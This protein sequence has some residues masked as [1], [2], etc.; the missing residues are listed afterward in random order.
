MLRESKE[1]RA[2]VF[3]VVPSDMTRRNEHKLKYFFTVRVAEHL[4]RLPRKVVECLSLKILKT[5][6]DVVL[7]NLL[8]LT[9]LEQGAWPRRS[10]GVPSNLNHATSLW[11][12][13]I[14]PAHITALFKYSIN[15]HLSTGNLALN[16][17]S[18]L[19]LYQTCEA[20]V[21]GVLWEPNKPRK[22]KMCCASQMFLL[23]QLLKQNHLLL[24]QNGGESVWFKFLDSICKM[25]EGVT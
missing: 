17:N 11:D 25:S 21:S 15:S 13:L 19:N 16:P 14:S 6:L 12:L 5:W 22:Y 1:D 24:G 18:T 9:L 20:R 23:Q 7:V 2:R 4:K 8:L 10:P 3:S